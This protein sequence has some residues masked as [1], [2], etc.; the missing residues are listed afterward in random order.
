VAMTAV[1]TGMV[2]LNVVNSQLGSIG[3]TVAVEYAFYV[4]FALG[5]LQIVSVLLSE[6]LRATGRST[7]ADR[8]DLWTRLVFLS[9]IF[10][11]VVAGIICQ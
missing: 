8:S 1:L 4:Y 11:L 10:G 3:Y 7:V 9:A 5:L 2:L 6:H